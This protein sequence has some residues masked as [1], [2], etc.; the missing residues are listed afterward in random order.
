M[1]KGPTLGR[2]VDGAEDGDDGSR[3]G[4]RKIELRHYNQ[5]SFF[6]SLSQQ[7][8]SIFGADDRKKAFFSING[9]G[10][11]SRSRKCFSILRKLETGRR[12]KVA[13]SD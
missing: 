11:Q 2:S 5:H 8:F 9:C 1:G 10:D 6:L 3:L 12:R 4:K 13:G 7:A